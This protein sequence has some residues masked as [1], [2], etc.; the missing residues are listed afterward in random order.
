MAPPGLAHS[1]FALLLLGLERRQASGSVHLGDRR[2]VVRRG[3]AFDVTAGAGDESLEEFLVRAGRLARRDLDAARHEA[4]AAGEPA[5]EVLVREGRLTQTTLRSSRR[6]LWLDRL[7]R[8]LAAEADP[9]F[10]P[11]A[12]GEVGDARGVPLAPLVLDALE[13]RAATGDAETVGERADHR[14]DWED[15]PHVEL[16]RK[17]SGVGDAQSALVAELLVESRTGPSRIAALVRAGLA[18]L[19]PPD[20][21]PVP[22]PR[23]PSLVP[24]GPAPEAGA[25][26]PPPEP[27]DSLLP[28]RREPLLNLDPGA[29][30]APDPPP[31]LAIPLWQPPAASASLEDPLDP[32]E[33][34]IAAL[35]EAEA[36]G[37]IRAEAWRSLARI[38]QRQYGSLEEAARAWREA[39]YA[40]PSHPAALDEAALLCAAMGRTDLARS[41]A[42]AE[43]N[44]ATTGVDRGRAHRR[45]AEMALRGGDVPAAARALEEAI[46]ADPERA[47]SALWLVRLCRTLGDVAG[48][49]RW[50]R[51][52]AASLKE[53]RPDRAR[54]LLAWAATL[55]PDDVELLEDYAAALATDGFEEAA[56][57][58]LAE[59]ARAT[60]NA[61]ERR[62]LLLDAGER[63]EDA[64]RPDLAAERMLEAFDAEPHADV[65]HEPL[66]ADLA[67]AGDTAL[68]AIVLEE[69]A[70]VT[71]PEHQAHWLDRAAA[72][73][74]SL[75]GGGEWAEELWARALVAD[76]GATGVLEALRQRAEALRAP[77]VLADAL[78]RAARA[79]M[80][81]GLPEAGPLLRELAQLAEG[82]LGSAPRALWAWECATGLDPND[83]HARE[84]VARLRDEVALSRDLIADAED[85]LAAAAP[86]ER[87][88]AARKL[89]TMLRDHPDEAARAI[90]LYREALEARPNDAVAAS[91]VER[92]MRMHGDL[93]GLCALLRRGAEGK[94]SPA[95]RARHLLLLAGFEWGRGHFRACAGACVRL[96]DLEPE[97]P[98]GIARLERAARRLDDLD[99]RH[100]AI[101][102][103]A[104]ASTAPRA[105]ARAMVAVALQHERSAAVEE[106]IEAAWN[107]AGSETPPADASALLLRYL[108]WV[109]PE[110]ALVA[111]DGARRAMGDSPPLLE[112]ATQV[113]IRA[114]DPQRA[115]GFLE[116]WAALMPGD[117]RVARWRLT[118]AVQGDDV[119]RIVARAEDA[120]APD[121]IDE[122]TAGAIRRAAS[123][124]EQLGSP[125]EAAQ[126]AL[127][128]ADRIAHR[129][130][131]ILPLAGRL[132]EAS[133]RAM[134]RVAAVERQIAHADRTERVEP[135]RRLAELHREQGNR[136]AEARTLL[137]LLADRPY[138]P[139][140]LSRLAHIYAETGET[141]RMMTV[142]GLRLEGAAD[143]KERQQA[144][145][146]LASAAV[147][148]D[149]VERADGFLHGLIEDADDGHRESAV[150]TAAGALVSLGHPV[151][152]V[153]LLLAEAERS[154]SDAAGRLCE[155]AVAIAERAAEE[156]A[157]ALR[158]AGRGL[159]LAPRNGRLLVAFERMAL[160]EGDVAT[161]T[162]TY[163][164]LAEQSMG[165]HGRRAI[166]Y[167]EA[168]WLERAGDL[169]AALRAYDHAFT[170]QPGEGVMFQA[171]ERIASELTD[172]EPLIRAHLTLAER[173][174]N[175][176]HRVALAQ[177]AAEHIERELDDPARAFDV[178]AKVW[179]ETGRMVL[180]DP[181]RALTHRWA[182]RDASAAAD[183]R[184][185]I[186]S[187]LRDWGE[188]TWDD[189]AKVD[190]LRKIA[191]LLTEDA[192]DLPGATHAIDQIS[193]LATEEDLEPELLAES[194]CDLAEY[195]LARNDPASAAPLLHRA[196]ALAPELP[197]LAP[198][199]EKTGADSPVRAA[200]AS[201]AGRA[202]PENA[203]HS[204]A[205]AQEL[206]ANPDTLREAQQLLLAVAR[207]DP[208]QTLALRTLLQTAQRLEATTLADTVASI[209][210]MFDP[211]VQAPDEEG[212]VGLGRHFADLAE[213]IRGSD[214]T[215][216]NRVAAIVWRSA[217]HLF[218]RRLEDY[219]LVGTDRIG[220]GGAR[221]L[222]QAYILTQELLQVDDVALF[223]HR[224]EERVVHVVPTH[225]PSVAVPVDAEEE[226]ASLLFRV[227]RGVELAR[228]EH[229]LV[230]VLDAPSR[231][232]LFESATAA[233]GPPDS[234]QNV[235]REAAD[236]A[237]E[238]W[239]TV[240]AQGQ[241]ELR[242]LLAQAA[243][244][245]DTEAAVHAMRVAAVRAGLSVSGGVV[246]SVAGLLWDEPA[247]A[248]ALPDTEAGYVAACQAS[249]ALTEL[250]RFCLSDD[251]LAARASAEAT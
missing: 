27:R 14:L 2:V 104:S 228:P 205:R 158:A 216:A 73:H 96:L 237:S 94:A 159:A 168:R 24:A 180:L 22:P 9:R 46:E 207:T 106:A 30:P 217:P 231:A 121:A 199:V 108:E 70:E 3:A 109:T 103:R 219:G 151:R 58:L 85:A 89:A 195:H 227:G 198:L 141:Q 65:L 23:R 11:E 204:I 40:D 8:A 50:A 13:R 34:Q 118:M 224:G 37:P 166:R 186:V 215:L 185:R 38:W 171:I 136:A 92:L 187:Q 39:A 248:D 137:R 153:E 150:T 244:P 33:R 56:I 170:L 86:H 52:A 125:A 213:A 43:V 211:D 167:R 148:V 233:F 110:R 57:S 42:E 122:Q 154:A 19:V 234:V 238:L 117:P 1:P 247:L 240:P 102:A 178:L 210:S 179:E 241:A 127:L 91:S 75:P 177:R 149:D 232:I 140:A 116:A 193:Q 142:L 145:L 107:A 100:R 251:Y 131:E 218:R 184:D 81:D 36:P 161:A 105:R 124:L 206:A 6:A 134:L 35:E 55:R 191:R 221:P 69:V 181:L 115:E 44:A 172:W 20:A 76:P 132:A 209:L 250:L 147:A 235:S 133:D 5:T 126:L 61:D 68:S 98:V 223:A 226:P 31:D 190:F 222:S 243:L 67:A 242:A 21:A 176:D 59:A 200:P 212:L 7:V 78:E 156:P 119:R 173:T 15:T 53:R 182:E 164:A 49:V 54:A 208:S 32:I 99:L 77:S 111:I 66:A 74:A 192:D 155:R 28:S 194:L 163:D 47:D 62:R 16:A 83:E 123:R 183:A 41:Y 245:V 249:P 128:A 162:R 220:T 114:R 239:R 25:A 197:R 160:A 229:L 95:D 112:L 138:D 174:P 4:A 101:A 225:P 189:D 152:A 88:Q 246:A 188:Q 175:I 130:P 45:R 165:P 60:P 12:P 82:P 214:A 71:L 120:L 48:A 80:L 87:P 236:L 10:E 51:H 63:A 169:P 196:Q 113:A 18:R 64:G 84:Q 201:T 97:H 144:L 26:T 72:A 79:C 139:T 90:A 157:L 230:T 29:T 202:E 135:L 93:P 146:D 143:P 17:W 203:N 129:D